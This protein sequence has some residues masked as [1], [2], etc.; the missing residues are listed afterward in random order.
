MMARSRRGRP[1][2]VAPTMRRNLRDVEK[3]MDVLFQELARDIGQVVLRAAGPDGTVPVERLGAVQAQARR[4]VDGVFVGPNGRP[5]GEDNEPLAP[6][7]QVVAEGQLAMID[8]V[9]A[10]QERIMRK[11]EEGQPRGAAPTGLDDGG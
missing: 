9:L 5:F 11:A 7:P 2:G 4:L 10:K 3:E 1:R 8:M 6:F